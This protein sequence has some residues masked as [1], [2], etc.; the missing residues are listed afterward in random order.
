LAFT[1]RALPVNHRL[2]QVCQQWRVPFAE[3]KL[4]RTIADLAGSDASRPAHL[5]DAIRYRPRR[6]S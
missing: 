4:A 1:R 2:Q 6:Q 5:A 3:L